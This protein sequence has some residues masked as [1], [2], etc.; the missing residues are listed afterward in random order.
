MIPVIYRYI[1]KTVILA[2][3]MVMAVVIGLIFFISLIGELKDIGIGDYG[4]LQAIMHSALRLPYSIYQFFPMLVLVGGM[5]GLGMLASNRELIVMR[6][7]GIS[8]SR[9]MNAVLLAAVIMIV[10]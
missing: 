10:I 9:L 5:M 2:T 6:T 1:A 3:M 8:V 4:L 7:S